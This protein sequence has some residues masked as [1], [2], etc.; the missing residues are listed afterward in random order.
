MWQI[1][2]IPNAEAT[3]A[4]ITLDVNQYGKGLPKG[5]GQQKKGY[6]FYCGE[7]YITT[8]ITKKP[9]LIAVTAAQ[10]KKWEQ[11]EIIAKPAICTFVG[12]KDFNEFLK[13]T[14]KKVLGE[15]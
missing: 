14:I 5:D 12:E 15:P 7:E 9:T 13:N 10:F 6:C 2:E 4:E 11:E 8:R 3:E 1:K